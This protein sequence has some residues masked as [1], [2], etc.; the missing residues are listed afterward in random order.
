MHRE[1]PPLTGHTR[2]SRLP[3]RIR[4]QQ[5]LKLLEMLGFFLLMT[6]QELQ[7]PAGNVLRLCRAYRPQCHGL[8]L[9]ELFQ[10]GPFA[11]RRKRVSH[12]ASLPERRGRTNICEQRA[13]L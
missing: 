4:S 1:H 6:A 13:E 3:V 7:H 9:E 10:N 8:R 12:A 11:G 2:E 5:Q